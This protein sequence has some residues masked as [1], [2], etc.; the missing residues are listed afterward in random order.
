VEQYWKKFA[1]PLLDRMD[2]RI[3]VFSQ[4]NGQDS[5]R[6][7]G[8]VSTGDLRAGIAAAVFIQ[9]QRQGKYNSVLQ[10]EEISRYCPLTAAA[11]NELNDAALLYGFSPRGVSACKKLA[12]TIADI[13]GNESVDAEHI[14]EAVSFRKNEGGMSFGVADML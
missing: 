12:R 10:P 11:E 7:A 4:P 5:D 14:R 3:P 9:R 1:G 6:Y 2:I 8:S 13:A